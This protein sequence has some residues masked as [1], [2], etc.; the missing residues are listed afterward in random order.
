MAAFVT[1]AGALCTP[2]RVLPA[3][4]RSRR[5]RTG[6]A[7][8]APSPQ[9]LHRVDAKAMAAAGT[10]SSSSSSSSSTSSSSVAVAAVPPPKRK[11]VCKARIVTTT[12]APGIIE[13]HHYMGALGDPDERFPAAVAH[14]AATLSALEHRGVSEG[15]SG[16]GAAENAAAATVA[17]P[18]RRWLLRRLPEGLDD[19]PGA[20][21]AQTPAAQSLVVMEAWASAAA[22]AVSSERWSSAMASCRRSLGTTPVVSLSYDTVYTVGRDGGVGDTLPPGAVVVCEAVNAAAAGEDIADALQAVLTATA[23]AVVQNDQALQVSILRADDAR[24]RGAAFFKTVE[25]YRSAAHWRDHCDG[26]DTAFLMR[27][28]GLR[29]EGERKQ[30]VFEA[31]G[32]A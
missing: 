18:Q 20:L 2:T 22:A 3:R 30:V 15:A 26:L 9:R 13:M 1:P 19:L 21:P 32:S 24:G 6:V 27:V 23:Q 31:V 12:T 4:A 16:E 14:H 28:K 17:A 25:V 5:S 10:G 7:M 29:A 8:E 11:G